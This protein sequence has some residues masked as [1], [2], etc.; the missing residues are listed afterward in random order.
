MKKKMLAL[1]L[2]VSMTVTLAAC[3]SVT[4]KGSDSKS[5]G[6][7]AEV[8]SGDA[9]S[10]ILENG[11]YDK[12]VVA[13]SEDPQDLEGDDVN[14]GS[15]YYWIYG[16]YESLFD[17]ADD[18]SGE[19]VP[20]MAE[21]YEPSEDGTSW[22]V[23]LHNDITD[24]EGN[25]ITA[26]DVKYC[27]EKIIAAGQAIRFDYYDSI[28]VIDDYTFK[29]N[30]KEVPPAISEIEF[31]LVR[32]L[33][34]SQKAYEDHGGMATTPVGTGCYKVT[35]F[36][37]GSKVV[38]EANDDYW[39]LKYQDQLTGRHKATVQTLELDVVTESS[40]AVVGL[41]NGTL[42]VC[43]Y[44]PLA[45]EEKFTSDPRYKVEEVVQGD[46]WYIAPNGQRMGEDLRKAVYYAIDNQAVSTAMG[47]QYVPSTSL[48][49]SAYADYDE[50]LEL[51]GTY[52]TDYDVDKAKDYLD[53]AGY[54]GETLK[55]ICV[56]NETATAAAQ[57]IQVLLE[58][59][60]IKLEINAVTNDTY[61]TMT[62]PTYSDQ[63]DMMINTIGGPSM[64]GSWHLLMDNEVNN[65]LTFSLIE[66][67]KLQELYETATAD[68]THDTEHMREVLDYVIDKGYL[69]SIANVS[70]AL[71][72]TANMEEM[73]YREGYYTPGAAKFIGQE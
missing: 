47:G 57:M 37:T 39:G 14:L 17:M 73:Y 66:D 13:I 72:Y 59:A 23:K 42:D 50:A 56:N 68:A 64:V 4:N 49:N 53:K 8:D 61:N 46:Y 21:S 65:G 67:S 15:R 51:D 48:G 38:M 54:K 71:V 69:Y 24:W 25:N 36:V 11:R 22:T 35:D 5:S 52:I 33:I 1:L 43:S 62:S 32:T 10:H 63:W 18:N 29:M 41:E 34:F 7:S 2:A 26:N 12:L 6:T 31:P 3:G 55:L 20:C 40:T 28:E 30:W 70:T 9:K 44:V 60:G 16:I 19:L 27:F 45:D 58:Q